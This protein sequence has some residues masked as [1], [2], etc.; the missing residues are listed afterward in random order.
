M[1]LTAFDASR[2]AAAEYGIPDLSGASIAAAL[3]DG[4]SQTAMLALLHPKVED[5]SL[6]SVR[7]TLVL[8]ELFGIDI[9]IPLRLIT[10]CP[11]P[12]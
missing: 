6:L 8:L 10:T 12:Y 2:D 9:E 11:Y 4:G 3:S 5:K 7:A 1:C